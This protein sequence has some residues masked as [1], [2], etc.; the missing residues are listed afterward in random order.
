MSVQTYQSAK[1]LEVLH[2]LQMY[3][4]QISILCTENKTA[5]L[6]MVLQSGRFV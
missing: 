3:P 5:N 4:Q 2:L 6:T 1:P